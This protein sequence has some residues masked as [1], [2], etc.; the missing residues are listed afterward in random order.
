MPRLIVKAALFWFSSCPFSVDSNAASYRAIS[1]AIPFMINNKRD[2]DGVHGLK[3][4]SA[5]HK[6]YRRLRSLWRS[7]PIIEACE[8]ILCALDRGPAENG[9]RQ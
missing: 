4:I 1:L 5:H 3:V 8:N 2:F 6:M 9:F 7:A